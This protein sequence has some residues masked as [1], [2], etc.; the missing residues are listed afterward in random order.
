MAAAAPIEPVTTYPLAQLCQ[1]YILTANRRLFGTPSPIKISFAEYLSTLPRPE[2]ITDVELI[3]IARI[4]SGALTYTG[5]MTAGA[6]EISLGALESS[7]SGS[8][9]ITDRELSLST[10]LQEKI[11]LL[12]PS[13]QSWLAAWNETLE[14]PLHIQNLLLHPERSIAAL[15]Q[16]HRTRTTQSPFG[17]P[18][19]PEQLENF[20]KTY[21]TTTPPEIE[22]FVMRYAHLTRYG[23][24]GKGT[25]IQSS[26]FLTQK[27]QC[28]K[29][30]GDLVSAI[31]YLY[32]N[33]LHEMVIPFTNQCINFLQSYADYK[34]IF[35]ALPQHAKVNFAR[36]IPIE[37]IPNIQELNKIL[38]C[39][40]YQVVAQNLLRKYQNLQALDSALGQAIIERRH[41]QNSH[42]ESLPTLVFLAAQSTAPEANANFEAML[43]NPD[44]SQMWTTGGRAGKPE[45]GQILTDAIRQSRFLSPA[46]K[47][48]RLATFYA[49]TQARRTTIG[50]L[51]LQYNFSTITSPLETQNEPLLTDTAPI[52]SMEGTSTTVTPAAQTRMNTAIASIQS[53]FP[54][55]SLAREHLTTLKNNFNTGRLPSTTQMEA[56]PLALSLVEALSQKIQAIVTAEGE[57]GRTRISQSLVSR[58]DQLTY[59]AGGISATL[60][61]MILSLDS[62]D[63]AVIMGYLIDLMKSVTSAYCRKYRIDP[64]N[65]VHAPLAQIAEALGLSPLP[66]YKPDQ[67]LIVWPPERIKEIAQSIMTAF[68]PTDLLERVVESRRT[69]LFVFEAGKPYDPLEPEGQEK[70]KEQIRHFE[71]LQLFPEGMSEA[72]KQ[73]QTLD[74]CF[75]LSGVKKEDTTLLTTGKEIVEALSDF[76]LDAASAKNLTFQLSPEFEA[77]LTT[78]IQKNLENRGIIPCAAKLEQINADIWTFLTA[79]N[80][81]TCSNE[82][83]ATWHRVLNSAD[84]CALLQSVLKTHRSQYALIT[85][86][87]LKWIDPMSQRCLFDLY[88]PIEASPIQELCNN[89]LVAYTAHAAERLPQAYWT[90]AAQRHAEQLIAR[91]SYRTSDLIK[92]NGARLQAL[93]VK[94]YAMIAATFIYTEEAAK[95]LGTLLR[96]R[97]DCDNALRHLRELLPEYPLC[98]ARPVSPDGRAT[99]GTVCAAMAA[100]PQLAVAGANPQTTY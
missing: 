11:K 66:F 32:E 79:E 98:F 82:I 48:E 89:K 64:G 71:A 70:L 88:T 39:I 29:N 67:H 41:L 36:I 46:Q 31:Q 92:E 62:N 91:F 14:Q 21:T 96:A 59:C 77:K 45:Y 44:R 28:I 83:K 72:D 52:A 58:A 19:T 43:T 12:L 37:I 95:C 25:L 56:Y 78:V 53:F 42:L 55:G 26:S 87:A 94:K 84:G 74:W 54:E 93:N 16:E 35:D 22:D 6:L 2:G 51:Q 85:D 65:E 61:E 40:S 90:H 18:W 81:E 10:A 4:F 27:E 49:A 9:A 57:P 23:L 63:D 15:P 47:T 38:Q 34:A 13:F 5:A 3:R 17:L 50:A 30:R 100:S 75:N 8:P 33:N 99:A 76:E 1:Q 80:P 20:F 97:T 69:N 7:L 73:A 60:S 24:I 68:S 86:A